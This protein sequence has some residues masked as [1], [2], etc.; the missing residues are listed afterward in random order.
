L[1]YFGKTVRNP[2]K[3]KGSGKY[4]NN[5]L[6]KHHVHTPKTVEVWG[7]DDYDNCLQFA[8]NFSAENMIVKSKQ[9]A[10]LKEETL[11]GGFEHLRGIPAW[12][13]GL[14]KETSAS[15]KLISEKRKGKTHS[16]E[17]RDKLSLMAKERPPIYGKTHTQA[18]KD[19][20]SNAKKGTMVGK[21]NHFYGKNHSQEAKEKISIANKK[22]SRTPTQKEILKTFWIGKKR[23][24]KNKKLLSEYASNRFWIVNKE[25]VV[26]HCFDINDERLLSGE[27]K[28][29]KKWN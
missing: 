4:W 15:V 26:R 28:R 16:Q 12:N 21:D 8:L 17:T 5:H 10:N 9:W 27:F 20:I 14:T 3:Y 22:Y 18:T 13:K 6:R 29:G 1:R 7:F 23:N 24:E 11:S 19:K 2:F 25:G